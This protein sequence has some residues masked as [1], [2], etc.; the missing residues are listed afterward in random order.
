[1][2][3]I[4]TNPN[5]V[6]DT[7]S[8]FSPNSIM[9][10]LESYQESQRAKT[11]EAR[12]AAAESRAQETHTWMMQ[13]QKRSVGQINAFN[14]WTQHGLDQSVFTRQEGQSDNDYYSNMFS[15]TTGDANAAQSGYVNDMKSFNS[16]PDVFNFQSQ[17]TKATAQY[18]E[19]Q[20]S[21][22]YNLYNKERGKN[23]GVSEKELSEGMN[24]AYKADKLWEKAVSLYGEEGAMSKMPGYVPFK[25]KES[26]LD[27]IKRQAGFGTGKV[28]DVDVKAEGGVNPLAV[29]GAGAVGY[30]QYRS[31]KSNATT[32][33]EAIV[34]AAKLKGQGGM[35]KD[36]LIK[37]YGKDYKDVLGKK[38]TSK[39]QILEAADKISKTK[40][41]HKTATGKVV[42]KIDDI[43]K[44][45]TKK[46]K[47]P[48]PSLK[49]AIPYAASTVG[50]AVGGVVGGDTGSVIGQTVGAG[51]M[52]N[53]VGK[54][55]VIS[56]SKYLASKAPS[57]AAKM[58]VM[59]MADSPAL[60]IGDIV[61]LGFGLMEVASLYK[62]WKALA[63]K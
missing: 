36:A 14:K 6:V 47:M 44:S 51:Y 1:M 29:A 45:I 60:P 4:Y 52:L 10:M 53:K 23:P 42:K 19:R 33:K 41:F 43:T 28:G 3:K 50:G 54:P 24:E 58:G 2:A 40:G 34:K 38:P 5:I 8:D 59:A 20:F 22:F 18:L 39:K 30:Q 12:A 46:I 16:N 61:A 35:N 15:S 57:I 26:M 7:D 21:E 13:N 27:W 37:K 49:G 9:K 32:I 63:E 62:E 48:K 11:A 25:A 55:S 17:R 56:F 31:A